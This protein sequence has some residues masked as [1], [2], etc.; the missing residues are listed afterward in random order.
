MTLLDKLLSGLRVLVV[1]DEVIIV[2]MIEGM[3]ADLGCRDVVSAPSVDKALALVDGRRFDIALL[4]MNLGGSDSG[5]V[6]EALERHGV[7]FVYCTGNRVDNSAK[8]ELD[9]P[10]LRKPFSAEELAAALSR[11]IPE[12]YST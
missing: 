4:D 5:P 1:E 8:G 11:L 2:M 9:R 3:L 12:D 6:A 7:P 10:I